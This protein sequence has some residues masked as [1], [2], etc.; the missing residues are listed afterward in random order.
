M[1][2]QKV[3][4]RSLVPK[5]LEDNYTTEGGNCTL[6]HHSRRFYTWKKGIYIEVPEDELRAQFTRW[7]AKLNQP[8]FSNTKQ[9]SS[10]ALHHIQSRIMLPGSLSR[11]KFINDME[12][13]KR[14]IAFE[15]GIAE[16][17]QL[18]SMESESCDLVAHSPD[19]FNLAKIPYDF[20]AKAE[21]PM[22]LK[23]INRILPD[24]EDQS[25]LQ[26]WFGYHLLPGLSRNKM[27]FFEGLGANGKSVVLLV[28]RLLLGEENVSSVPLSGFDPDKTFKLAAT[29][30]KFANICE[31]V[32]PVSSRVEEVL[33][34]YVNGGVF[35][36]ERKFKDP[37]SM[38]PSAKLTFATNEMPQFRDR[39][40]GIWRRIL[41]LKFGV[42]ISKSEQNRD[43]LEKDFWISSREL[44]GV[45]NWAI[46]GAKDL[47]L[48]SDFP[49][50]DRKLD[51]VRQLKLNA[52]ILRTW[53]TDNLEEKMGHEESTNEI[54]ARV[55]TA[56]EMGYLPKVSLRDVCR[57]IEGVFPKC[58]RPS[59]AV[60]LPSGK[61][62]RVV[63]N[64]KLSG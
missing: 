2:S 19:F 3:P 38:Y 29:D 10:E 60:K 62:G 58:V 28:L 27:M 34:Q 40:E 25:T 26:Q 59:N 21:S 46:E 33:K 42:T 57:E 18:L 31:E 4:A 37:F 51:E 12:S 5:F 14:F 44:P 23:I 41:Y 24:A 20:S 15:N 54:F 47:M 22:W 61:R 39:S 52:D 55:K 53:V 13:T 6:R 50:S 16:L 1:N 56:I 9:A 35:T 63:R 49:S 7:A 64:V 30:G 32:G 43:Y 45:L 36:V 11:N 48:W 17:D 8:N